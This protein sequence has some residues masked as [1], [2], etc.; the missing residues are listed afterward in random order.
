[1]KKIVLF[2]A[3]L[4]FPFSSGLAQGRFPIHLEMGIGTGIGFDKVGYDN[5]AFLESAE[6][7]LLYG[8]SDLPLDLGAGAQIMR[9][10]RSYGEPVL[11]AS[12][13]SMQMFLTG[14]YYWIITDKTRLYS[15][16]SLGASHD[17][18]LISESFPEGA[19]HPKEWTL[20]VAP[21]IGIE[22][23]RHCCVSLSCNMMDRAHS[24]LGLSVAFRI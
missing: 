24:F 17:I 9:I 23:W 3:V 18:D 20:Y 19:Y 5:N 13:A 22:V 15:G 6:V 2:I 8:L 12:Y 1:M 10:D 7:G 21:K 11:M 16:L 4:S 14:K